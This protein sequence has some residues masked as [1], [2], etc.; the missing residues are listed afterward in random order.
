MTEKLDETDQ[1]I[2]L[3]FSYPIT[4]SIRMRS[5]TSL[6]QSKSNNDYEAV[7]RYN[8]HN[9]NYQVGFTYDY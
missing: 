4:Q 9:A 8:Y 1:N 6:G 3:G 7:Y 5:T 2:N